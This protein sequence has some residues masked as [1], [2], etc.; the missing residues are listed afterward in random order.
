MLLLSMLLIFGCSQQ[1]K[2][3]TEDEKTKI[4]Q[5]ISSIMDEIN[6]GI[7]A[8]DV[9]RFS[10]FWLKSEDLIYARDGHATRGFHDLYQIASDVHSNPKF[11]TFKIS[12]DD[13]IIR[14]LGRDMVMVTGDCYLNDFPSE[15]CP[16]SLKLATTFLFE[17]INGSWLMTIGHEST[18]DKF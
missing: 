13:M 1:N 2:E 14:V 8:H 6:V 10:S 3:L 4:E 5:E 9:D 11:Q 7:N 12:Y 17:N 18:P 16:K 15:D